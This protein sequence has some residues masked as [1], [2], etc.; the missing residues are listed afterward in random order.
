[1]VVETSWWPRSS[2]IVRMSAPRWR[3]W[4]AMPFCHLRLVESKPEN[5]SY[6]WKSDQYPAHPRHIGERIKKRRFDLKMTAVMCR[7]ILGVNK[8]TLVDWERGRRKPSRENREKI[9]RFLT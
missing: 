1:M 8:S 6:L 2:W 9:E 5:D 3:A 7:K 4:V